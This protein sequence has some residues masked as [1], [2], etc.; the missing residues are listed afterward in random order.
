MVKNHLKKL[1]SPRSWRVKRK[2]EK[3]IT[4]P[5]TGGHCLENAMALSVIFKNILKVAKTTKE[6]KYILNEKEV[7]INGKKKKNHRLPIGLFDLIDLTETGAR[8]VVLIDNKGKLVAKEHDPKSLMISKV[9]DKKLI[10]GKINLM[11]YNGWN[12]LT[13]NK[14]IKTNDSVLIDPKTRKIK[15]TIKFE[16]GATV[17]LVGGRHIGATGNIENINDGKVIINIDENMIET[18]K[19]FV[20]VIGKDKPYIEM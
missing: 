14:D 13:D 8:Y 15:E 6:A 4:R 3:Y 10:K 2:S 18:S 16:K 9:K 19:D 12:I 1:A 7:L 17:L 5:N 11:L 20:Y